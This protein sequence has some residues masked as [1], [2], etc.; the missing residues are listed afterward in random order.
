[1]DLSSL[2]DEALIVQIRQHAPENYDPTLLSIL[3]ERHRE[4]VVRTCCYYLKDRDAADDIAQ[5]VWIRVLTRLHQFRTEASFIPW[6]LGIV[7]NR[8]QSHIRQSKRALH[9]E[10]SQKI[11]DSLEDELDTENI[12]KPTVEI[13]E[14]L[15][16]N[17]S[18]EEK[19]L[20]SLKYQQGWSIKT[21]AQSLGLSEDTVKKRLSRTRAKVE[22][23][24]EASR[25]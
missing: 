3:F 6:L 21:I 9:R 10:I 24:L 18:G 15:M 23:L 19:L 22:K 11:V 7:H 12:N 8:C 20:L 4:R 2:S 17:I 16:E 5:E 25:K 14:D 1:M 13:L